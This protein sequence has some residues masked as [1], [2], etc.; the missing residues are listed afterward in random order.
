MMMVFE[1]ES[2][3][4]VS[5]EESSFTK[6]PSHSVEDDEDDDSKNEDRREDDEDNSEEDESGSE[7]RNESKKDVKA[8][9]KKKNFKCTI[10]GTFA[11]P[12]E[13]NRYYICTYKHKEKNKFEKIHMKCEKKH[14]FDDDEGKCV[15]DD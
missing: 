15:E 3:A 9:S 8:K 11:D 5:K 4:D 13:D 7:E 1:A 12:K 6:Q 14:V 10:E 2:E